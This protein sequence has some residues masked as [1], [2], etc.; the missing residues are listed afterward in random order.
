[1]LAEVSR[2][3]GVELDGRDPAFRRLCNDPSLPTLSDEELR[4][5][6]LGLVK[7]GTSLPC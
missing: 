3:E 6:V 4:D 7:L 2:N 1:M 5:R